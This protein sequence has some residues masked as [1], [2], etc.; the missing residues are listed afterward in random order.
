MAGAAELM[1]AVTL[2]S[3]SCCRLP[4]GQFFSAV[5]PQP[6]VLS[7]GTSY[8]LPITF[9]PTTEVCRYTDINSI[10]T[11]MLIYRRWCLI[12]LVLM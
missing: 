11:A 1:L 8:G 5:Y 12:V 7:A 3:Q 10:V 6:V 9:R 4:G 2:L